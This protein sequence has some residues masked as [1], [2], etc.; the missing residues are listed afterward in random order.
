MMK[1]KI[2]W[3]S[4]VGWTILFYLSLLCFSVMVFTLRI[5][6]ELAAAVILFPW[7]PYAVGTISVLTGLMGWFFLWESWVMFFE[8]PF[9]ISRHMIKH[10][11]KSVFENAVCYT[12][13][14]SVF[15]F[16]DVDFIEADEEFNIN[17]MPVIVHHKINKKILRAY[18]FYDAAR[19]YKFIRYLKDE[20]KKHV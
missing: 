16:T 7:C 20:K 18:P 2:I 9:Y 12:I 14:N 10:D 3:N 6:G 1:H 15:T 19:D 11:G 8:Q 13:G 17:K 5:Q 4:V